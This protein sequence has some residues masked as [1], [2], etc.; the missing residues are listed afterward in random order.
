MSFAC[1]LLLIGLGASSAVRPNFGGTWA[2]EHARS[3]SVPRDMQQTMTVT[4]EGDK[5]NVETKI[6]SPQG[7]RVVTDAYTLDGKE[8]EFT[9]QPGPAEVIGKG[10]RTAKWLPADNGFIVQEEFQTKSPQGPANNQITR[11]WIMWADGSLSIDLY[12]DGPR[13]SFETKRIFTKKP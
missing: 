8:A 2:L 6:V 13:G 10:K 7:E 11:K 12:Q 4:H 5:L 3:Y 9:P 1:L